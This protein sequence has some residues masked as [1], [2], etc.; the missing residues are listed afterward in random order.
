MSA[1][2]YYVK[3]GPRR[4]RTNDKVKARL[5]AKAIAHA[6]N[7]AE[8]VHVVT[9]RTIARFTPDPTYPMGWREERFE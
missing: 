3:G 7:V 4:I 5:Q 2:R 1:R 9:G 8:V 6:G